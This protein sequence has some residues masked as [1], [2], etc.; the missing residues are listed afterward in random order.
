MTRTICVLLGGALLSAVS[1][2]GASAK[3]PPGY[4]DY[5]T[6]KTCRHIERSEYEEEDPLD[7]RRDTI[8]SSAGNA[9]AANIAT[10]TIDP[11]PAHA[12]RTD[13]H[14]DGKRASV[15]ITRYQQNKSIPP[16]GLSTTTISEQAGPGAQSS[17]SMQK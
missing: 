12:A 17:T 6:Y 11:W 1:A 2:G 4:Y 10:Q 14:L 16:K 7:S 3:C 15:G 8:T 5:P 13:S 9:N